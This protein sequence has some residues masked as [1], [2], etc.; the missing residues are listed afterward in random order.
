MF[1]ISNVVCSYFCVSK[2]TNLFRT[3]EN[4]FFT[5]VLV[6]TVFFILFVVGLCGM[7]NKKSEITLSKLKRGSVDIVL[8][9]RLFCKRIRGCS[10]TKVRFGSNFVDM[11]TP[12]RMIVL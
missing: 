9:R 2:V 4:V 3:V 7:L 6:E 8:G 12:L 1:L 11:L 5:C 10:P